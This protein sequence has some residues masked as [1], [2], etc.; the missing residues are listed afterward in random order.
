MREEGRRGR[1]Q[2]CGVRM[3]R[4]RP[5]ESLA[6]PVMGRGGCAGNNVRAVGGRSCSPMQIR[7][8]CARGSGSWARGRS[9]GGGDGIAHGVGTSVR[10]RYS[11][12]S[13]KASGLSVVNT[14]VVEGWCPEA[15]RVE[16]RRVEAA[17][18]EERGSFVGS[19]AHHR[20]LWP[21]IAH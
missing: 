1:K 7:G 3:V 12:S 2:A 9:R 18:V 5:W 10:T 20:G 15:I 13:K 6:R 8:G 11:R 19:K 17:A 4:E 16:V 21:A 14:S